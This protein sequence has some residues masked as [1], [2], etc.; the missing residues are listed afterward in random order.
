MEARSWNDMMLIHL[1]G[2]VGPLGPIMMNGHEACPYS[3][4]CKRW[5]CL[6]CESP[7]T[8]ENSGSCEGNDHH[9]DDSCHNP[10]GYP[11]SHEHSF[12]FNNVPV[13]K[14]S[15]L[16]RAQL[17]FPDSLCWGYAKSANLTIQRYY[18]ILMGS[19]KAFHWFIS[20]F[21]LYFPHEYGNFDGSYN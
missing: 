14:L 12:Q 16:T 5:Y 15:F 13:W 18:S 8:A 10:N 11:Y 20:E 6:R 9:K 21:G 3:R 19:C 1:L 2:G 17:P 7:V 4:D